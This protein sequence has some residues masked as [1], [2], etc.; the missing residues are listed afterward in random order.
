MD[1]NTW[2]NLLIAVVS[3]VVPTVGV[4]LAIIGWF[5]SRQLKSIDK[6]LDTLSTI[7]KDMATTQTTLKYLGERQDDFCQ[8]LEHVETH[9]SNQ[10]RIVRVETQMG[11]MNDELKLLRAFR[12]EMESHVQTIKNVAAIVPKIEAMLMKG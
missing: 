8:R 9:V 2:I 6:K 7:E 11:A 10:E 12:H 4:F 1:T 5:A 3:I